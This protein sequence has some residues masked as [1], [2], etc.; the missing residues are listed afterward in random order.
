MEE[1]IFSRNFKV[2][3][4]KKSN[5]FK[6]G[7]FWNHFVDLLRLIQNLYKYPLVALVKKPAKQLQYIRQL[8]AKLVERW[9]NRFGKLD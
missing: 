7:I 8:V 9:S 1:G 6:Y 3:A 2:F 5:I 4:K